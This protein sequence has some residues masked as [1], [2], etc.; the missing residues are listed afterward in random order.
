MALENTDKTWSD[1]VSMLRRRW[2]LTFSVMM[3]VASGIIFIAYSLPAVYQSSATILIEQQGIPTEF[4]QTTVSSY[5]EQLLQTIYQRVVAAPKVAELIE[6]FDLY[7]EKRGIVPDDELFLL[8]RD[9]TAMSPKNVQ[10]VNSRTG[11]EAIITFGFEI[12]FQYSDPVKARDVAEELANLFVDHNA[13]LR[14]ETAARTSSFLDS[15]S[16]QLEEQLAEVAQRIAIFKEANPNNLPDDQGVNIR[17]WERLREESDRHPTPGDA[18]DKGI[19]RSRACRYAAIPT[20]I[21]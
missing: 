12:A 13:Q 16:R 21:G 19:A 14:T 1:Y 2:R 4:V 9:S 7:P 17:T 6:K 18:G 3:I 5:A 15:E 20:R 8:F 11:R 10:S